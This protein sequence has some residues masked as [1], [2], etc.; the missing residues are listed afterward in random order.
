MALLRYFKPANG[1]PDPRGSLSTA[2]SSDVLTEMNREVEEELGRQKSKKRGPY[3]KFSPSQRSLIGKY[4]SQH[5]PTAAS[6]HFSR[7]LEKSVSRSTAKSIK[8]DYDEEIRKRRRL[9]ANGTGIVEITELPAKKIGRKVL[10]GEDLDMKVQL[11]LRKVREGGGAV[12]A[13]IAMAA[14][15]GILQKCNRSMLAKNGG[16]VLLTRYWAHSLLKRMKFVQRKATTSLSKMTDTNFKECKRSFLNDIV[17][18]IAMEEIPGELVLNWDQT[19]IKL[20]PSSTWTMERKG[21]RRVEMM[22]VNDKR[23]ITAIFCGSASGDFLPI[24]LIYI[25]KTPRCHPRYVFPSDWNVTHSPKHW[26]NEDTMVE[27]ITE[28]V[29]PYVAQVRERLGTDSAALVVMDNFKG[30]ATPKIM[31]LLEENN[32]LVSWLPPNTTDRLQPMDISVNKPAKDYLKNQFGEW[33]SDMVMQQLEGQDIEDIEGLEIMP[34]DL[35]M[36]VLKQISAKWLVG[37]VEYITENPQFIVNGFI[38][39]GI[40]SAVDGVV[41]MGSLESEE[42]DTEEF[43]SESDTEDFEFSDDEADEVF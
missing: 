22:G 35:G 30:Q 13:R 9:D 23:Q 33:Y 17:T 31:N 7:K 39:S 43:E 25:G 26:S 36:P 4:T 1:L 28:I 12:S 41:N 38:Q 27:Y 29:L 40:T 20:V 11:Y 19:G 32:I 14:A 10:L 21:E 42:T 15:R 3:Q 6:R 16:H 8:K 2:I 18:T 24:Q 37:M 5:G 34:I